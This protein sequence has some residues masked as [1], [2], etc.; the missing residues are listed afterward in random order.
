MGEDVEPAVGLINLADIML[1]FATGLM[2]A[3]VTFWNVDIGVQ[4]DE[5]LETE[6]ITEVTDIEEARELLQSG[7]LAYSEVGSVYKDPETGKLYMLTE[8]YEGVNAAT[9]GSG[10]EGTG[11]GETDGADGS[12]AEGEGGSADQSSSSP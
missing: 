12:T 2:M 4:F 11:T 8:D 10:S 6:Q 1:V 9:S 3:L 7:D 5:V